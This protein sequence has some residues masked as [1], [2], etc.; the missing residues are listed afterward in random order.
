MHIFKKTHKPYNAESNNVLLGWGYISVNVAFPMRTLE[1]IS[2]H[3]DSMLEVHN[4]DTK[5]TAIL[6]S[7][8][9]GN[10]IAST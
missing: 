9:T 2:V 4:A 8:K 7:K 10:Y 3:V 6:V 1:R 5:N